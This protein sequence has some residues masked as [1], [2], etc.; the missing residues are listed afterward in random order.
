VRENDPSN[1]VDD[2][3]EIRLRDQLALLLGDAE[4]KQR[5][6][7][8]CMLSICL[9]TRRLPPLAPQVSQVGDAALVEREAVTLPLDHAIG[10]EL[11]DVGSGLQSR[12]SASADALTVAR[13]LRPGRIAIVFTLLRRG[14]LTHFRFCCIAHP[15]AIVPK[16]IGRAAAPL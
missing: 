13:F 1:V 9:T 2:R 7:C 15:V 8:F 16:D 10:F 14:R 11:A 5:C 6:L 4:A 3:I 12:C